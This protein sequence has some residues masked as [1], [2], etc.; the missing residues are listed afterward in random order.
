LHISKIAIKGAGHIFVWW[1]WGIWR[2]LRY[3]LGN[4]EL[5]IPRN[6]RRYSV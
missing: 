2:T 6:C 4:L 5:S 1:R 3:K